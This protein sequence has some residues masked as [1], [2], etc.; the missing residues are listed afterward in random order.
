MGLTK[1][2]V[3]DYT[4]LPGII[5]IH[6]NGTNDPVLVDIMS[7]IT[8]TNGHIYVEDLY[9]TYLDRYEVFNNGIESYIDLA[10][11]EHS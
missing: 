11:V 2:D 9:Y 3:Y 6:I 10:V 1:L 5:R 4:I 8:H 7:E